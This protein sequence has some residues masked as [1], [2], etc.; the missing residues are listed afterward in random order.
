MNLSNPMEVW[1][2]F[3]C[4]YDVDPIAQSWIIKPEVGLSNQNI[5][6]IRVG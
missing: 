3:L 1:S 6:V 2:T 5:H 4:K